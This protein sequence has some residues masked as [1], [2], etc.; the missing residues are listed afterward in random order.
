MG[1]P[2]GFGAN[3]LAIISAFKD[4]KELIAKLR[5]LS[6]RQKVLTALLLVLILGIIILA[7]AFFSGA[8]TDPETRNRL[9]DSRRCDRTHNL[10]RNLGR[11]P[12]H[13]KSL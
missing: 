1:D 7:Q 3:L 13:I 4:P 5:G 2:V 12:F 6:K 9:P 10:Y 8:F 11:R